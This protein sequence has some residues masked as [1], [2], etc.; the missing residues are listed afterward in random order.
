MRR[1]KGEKGKER[2]VGKAPGDER[3][4][5]AGRGAVKGGHAV[6]K[7]IHRYVFYQIDMR[8]GDA[9]I[10]LHN[11]LITSLK[12]ITFTTSTHGISVPKFT[13]SSR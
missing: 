5:I 4:F 7:L 1:V 11:T 10:G 13:R 9:V 6:A 2:V 12:G 8:L 3:V